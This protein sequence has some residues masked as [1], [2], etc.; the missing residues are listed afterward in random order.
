MESKNKY[1]TRRDFLK[2]SWLLP[3]VVVVGKM[4]ESVLPIEEG[5]TTGDSRSTN[6]EQKPGGQFASVHWEI[7]PNGPVVVRDTMGDIPLCQED[8]QCETDHQVCDVRLYSVATNVNA[9][10]GICVEGQRK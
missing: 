3:T 1:L 6:Q 4:A 7:G 8:S 10:A 5:T 2:L 9:K